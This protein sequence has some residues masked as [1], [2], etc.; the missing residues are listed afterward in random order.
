MADGATDSVALRGAVELLSGLVVEGISTLP[1][2][3][4]PLLALDGAVLFAWRKW[5]W[6]VAYAVGAAAFV[7][8]MFTIPEAWGEIGG[9]FGRWLLLFT[10]LGALAVAVW[11]VDVVI[12]R[13][14]A[15]PAAEGAG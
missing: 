12:E 3:L 6:G 5:V 2:A 10:G 13:R 11:V 8:V 1:L 7:L 14:R 15:V 9:G 4:L